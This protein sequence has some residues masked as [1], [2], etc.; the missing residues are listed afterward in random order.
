MVMTAGTRCDPSKPVD[1]RRVDLTL[2]YFDDCPHWKDLAA[3]LDTLSAEIP[4]LRITRQMVTTPEQ[5]EAIGFR[6]S[7]SLL[8]DGVDAFV[9]QGAAIGLACRVYETLNGP[10]GVPTLD[11]LRQRL[12]P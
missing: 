12:K 11:Q 10:S 6:G 2:L 4:G 7:P 5:A 8:V 3:D 9:E 1:V